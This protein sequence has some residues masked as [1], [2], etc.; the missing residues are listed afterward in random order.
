MG[1]F[2]YHGQVSE[3]CDPSVALPNELAFDLFSLSPET[4]PTHWG[5]TLG[6]LFSHFGDTSRH[7]S[8]GFHQGKN[9]FSTQFQGVESKKTEDWNT[10]SSGDF[11]FQWPKFSAM[12]IQMVSRYLWRNLPKKST[13][14]M[15]SVCSSDHNMN[16]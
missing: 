4:Q 11:Q 6:V 8:N 7:C 5:Q 9:S 2:N 14:Q 16:I 12:S 15:Q 3:P 1:G 10:D 13:L